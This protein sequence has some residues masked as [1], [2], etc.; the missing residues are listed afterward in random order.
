MRTEHRAPTHGTSGT[1]APH[2]RAAHEGRE[3]ARG[4]ELPTLISFYGG[5]QYYYDAADQLRSDCERLGMPHHIEELPTEGMVW[6]EIC[7]LKIAFYQRMQREHGAVLWVDVDDRL[8]A[9]PEFLR[10]CQLDLVGFGGRFAYIRDHNPLLTARYWVPSILFFGPG[11]RAARFLQLMADIEAQ[12]DEP[13]TDD[14]VLQEAWTRHTEQ[15]AVGHLPPDLVSRSA[16]TTTAATAFIHGDS[17]SVATARGQVLQHG[18]S[19]HHRSIRAAAMAQEAVFA[20]RAGRDL[21]TALPLARRAYQIRP[22]DS[23]HVV[24]LGGYLTLS[25]RRNEAIDLL[26]RH[27]REYPD[28]GEAG[29]TRARLL[30]PVRRYDEAREQV[31]ALIATGDE[32]TAAR[33]E[34]LRYDLDLAE[35]ATAKGLSTAQRPAMWWMGTPYPGNFGDVLGPWLVHHLTGRPPRRDSVHKPALTVGSIIKFASPGTRVWGSGTPRMGDPLCPD[36]HYFAVRGPETARAV[37]AYGGRA[38]TVLG[39]PALLL[40]RLL[41]RPADRRPAYGLGIIRHVSHNATPLR[42]EGVKDIRLSVVG[43]AGIRSVIDQIWDCERVLS[44]SLHGIITAHAYGI[45]ARRITLQDPHLPVIPG[46]GTKYTDYFGSVG[47]P[48]QEP[49][50]VPFDSVIDESWARH[51]D[52][53]VDPRFDADALWQAGLEAFADE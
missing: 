3:G 28:A 4:G 48:E 25:G 29:L 49:H 39:D 2:G 10:G 30:L 19:A 15:L 17:A 24:R 41:P 16:A 18:D 51:V 32:R 33:A 42:L 43:D 27:L 7:R 52:E 13:V 23:A 34:A 8:V 21:D 9:L 31:E 35:E 11:E 6:A 53:Q 36:A 45:P 12:T 50:V 20:M 26:A 14:W 37:G 38:P 47:L 5:S 22:E 44:T 46:D 40:P 1:S